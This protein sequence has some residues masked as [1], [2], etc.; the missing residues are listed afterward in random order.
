M[1]DQ[2]KL[3]G[4][5][6]F[7][8]PLNSDDTGAVYIT[9]STTVYASGGRKKTKSLDIEYCVSDCYK[10]IILNFSVEGKTKKAREASRKERLAKV[11]LLRDSLDALET[12][13]EN[14]EGE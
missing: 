6:T 11:E 12:I 8:N 10:K 7:L 13:L 4:F 3:E 9:A 14:F 1:Y 2:K 5:R